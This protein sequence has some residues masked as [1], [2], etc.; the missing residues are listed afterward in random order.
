MHR[1]YVYFEILCVIY[2]SC[3]VIL[4]NPQLKRALML[5]ALLVNL[6]VHFLWNMAISHAMSFLHKLIFVLKFVNATCSYCSRALLSSVRF[7][8]MY[9]LAFTCHISTILQCVQEGA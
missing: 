3:G 1:R 4:Q 8:R 5:K 2:S 6:F 7:L 9:Y